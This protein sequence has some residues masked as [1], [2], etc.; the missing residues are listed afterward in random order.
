MLDKS[1]LL[2]WTGEMIY[3]AIWQLGFKDF[4]RW[5]DRDAV[6]TLLGPSMGTVASVYE[7]RLL[8]RSMPGDDPDASMKD[9]SR[10][11]LHFLRRLMPGQNLWYFRRGVNGLEDSMGDLF[12]L[13]GVSQKERTELAANQQ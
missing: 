5:S 13:P 11:D 4:S 12:D 9:F 6:E 8:A 10:S 7:R 2:G 1:N 3:P